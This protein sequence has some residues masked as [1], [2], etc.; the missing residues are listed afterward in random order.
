[1]ITRLPDRSSLR[2]L[3]RKSLPIKLG[4]MSNSL[5]IFMQSPNQCNRTFYKI[6]SISSQI[7]KI[8]GMEIWWCIQELKMLI[9]IVKTKCNNLRSQC[10]KHH[11]TIC[12]HRHHRPIWGST[13]S[14]HKINL[15][16][17]INTSSRTF[18]NLLDIG[19]LDQIYCIN[20]MKNDPKITRPPSILEIWVCSITKLAPK[21][22]LCSDTFFLSFY[23]LTS[24]IY[25]L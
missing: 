12:S 10:L 4:V 3:N 18:I 16:R 22:L 23:N 9:Q 14:I 25:K 8:W 2:P 21:N 15:S 11:I 20:I 19:K 13:F 5:K 6:S 24:H 1:M 7:I 17:G